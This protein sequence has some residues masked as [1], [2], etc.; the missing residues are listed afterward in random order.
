MKLEKSKTSKNQVE[1]DT[2]I[3]SDLGGKAKK[4]LRG[5]GRQSQRQRG[6]V[7]EFEFMHDKVVTSQDRK[8]TMF[9]YDHAT[10]SLTD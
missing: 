9:Y 3:W 1:K 7:E 6:A 2:E 8:L 5:G 10:D 4:H